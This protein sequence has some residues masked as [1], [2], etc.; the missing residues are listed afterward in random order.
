[1]LDYYG[2]NLN[3]MVKFNPLPFDL[4][5]KC[6]YSVP[7]LFRDTNEVTCNISVTNIIF[8]YTLCQ[9]ILRQSLQKIT[10]SNPT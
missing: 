6:F 7:L 5:I 2:L 9:W 8:C 1:M 4:V 3:L 10:T